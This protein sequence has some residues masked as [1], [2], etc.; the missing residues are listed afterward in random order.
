[1]SLDDTVNRLRSAREEDSHLHF[2]I[3]PHP[4]RDVI[5][6]FLGIGDLKVLFVEISFVF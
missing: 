2:R 1:M 6:S 3:S 4:V 5:G